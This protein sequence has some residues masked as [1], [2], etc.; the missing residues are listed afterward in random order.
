[1]FD[2]SHQISV[3]ALGSGC[4]RRV[5]FAI[6]S[7]VAWNARSWTGFHASSKSFCRDMFLS[8]VS[9]AIFPDACLTKRWKTHKCPKTSLVPWELLAL[10]TVG[11]LPLSPLELKFHVNRRHVRGMLATAC[12]VDTYSCWEEVPCLWVSGRGTVSLWSDLPCISCPQS[13]HPCTG[14]ERT[15]CR[16][17]VSAH[18]VGNTG[19]R[20]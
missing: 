16:W 19:Q 15:A 11:L 5:A 14:S 6:A 3:W 18:C 8:W 17:A 20:S 4:T 13:N 10:G 1:M 9:G 12:Q 7:F 2:V